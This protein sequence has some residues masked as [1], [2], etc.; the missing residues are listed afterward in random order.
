MQVLRFNHGTLRAPKTLPDGS[1]RYDA[2]ISRA[3]VFEYRNNDGSITKE[4][5]P[6]DEIFRKD[7]LESFSGLAVTNDHPYAAGGLVTIE[8]R[9]D[10]QRGFVL[11]GVRRDGNEVIASIVVTDPDLLKEMQSGK[12][13]VSCGYLQDIVKRSGTTPDGERYD[14]IQTN[15]RG[16]HVA[17]VDVAR[18]GD[19]AR[20]RMDAATMIAGVPAEKGDVMD[21]T[22]ALAALALANVKI[23]ELQA[24]ADSAEKQ[25]NDAKARLDATNAE[26]DTAKDK[27]DKAD[28]ARMD[29]EASMMARAKERIALE[30]S[31]EQHLRTDGA[32]PD[33]SK[34]SNLEIKTQ[35]TEKLTGKSMK[36]QSEAYVNARYDGAMETAEAASTALDDVRRVADDPVRTD[37][38]DDATKARQDM[39]NRAQN[40]WKKGA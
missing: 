18:A 11:E 9:K 39:I 40:A 2:V 37:V 19:C 4:W 36:G 12:N 15:I 38:A 27:A 14:A 32:S 3:G 34:L 31:A 10:L 28:K 26:L 16:N 17:I 23:G 30:A 33:V 20:V 13:Q 8:N 22:Q 25:F 6:A 21:L 1:V 29:A 7:S 35:I 5:H 24:R